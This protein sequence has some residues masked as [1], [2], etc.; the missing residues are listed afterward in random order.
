MA[1]K[2]YGGMLLMSPKNTPSDTLA[3]H[4]NTK[5]VRYLRILEDLQK[6]IP[7]DVPLLILGET[8]VGKDY[9]VQWIHRLSPRRNEPFITISCANLTEDLFESEIFG[10]EKGA[11]TDAYEARSGKLEQVGEGTL[12]LNEVAAIPLR[13]QPKLLRV[14]EEKSFTPLG[15]S[16]PR[17]MQGRII[18]SSNRPL[19]KLVK[20][21]G[22]RSDL[23]Y[24]LNVL[25]FTIPPLRDRR[26]DIPVLTRHFVKVFSEKYHKK[27]KGVTRHCLRILS[28]HRWKGNVRELAHVIE[29]A[30]I[31]CNDEQIRPEHLPT[32]RIFSPE[33]LVGQAVKEQ[34]SLKD[35]EKAYIERVL[36][37]THYNVSHAARILGIARKT[38]I[39]KRKKYKL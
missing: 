32:D 25:S 28:L 33:D 35:L 18:A 6:A 17:K 22:F 31:L 3:D 20:E 10:F 2:G 21:G 26:D 34:W 14:M 9:V 5:N 11:F 27:I 36:Q 39:E 30:V 15:G 24:R 29:R 37:Y 13:V 1:W 8:G 19:D 23:Y 12:Y 4:V 38:L 7:L 16:T